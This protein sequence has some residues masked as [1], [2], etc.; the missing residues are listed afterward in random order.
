MPTLPI[1]VQKLVDL[2]KNEN[3][4]FS[5]FARVIESDSGFASRILKV[6]N[7]AYYGL[8]IKATTL[9]RAI[10]ALGL[11]YVKS[12]TLGYHL[13]NVL[14]SFQTVG[15]NMDNYWRESLLRAVMA[16]QI[17]HRYCPDH[18]EEAF[19][20]G[21]LQN[22]GI[23]FLVQAFG[24]PYAE[25]WS[26]IQKSP[27]TL[28]QLERKLFQFNHLKAAS[29]ITKQWA[30]PE[31]LSEPI[32]MHHY[33]SQSE[34]SIADEVK[35]CQ[36]AYFVGTLSLANIDS[37]SEDD[38]TLAD[39][40]QSAFGLDKPAL[41]EILE[42]TRQEFYSVAQLFA[43]IVPDKVDVAELL[44]NANEML[45]ELAHDSYLKTFD[46]EAELKQL[47]DKCKKLSESAEFYRHQDGTDPLTGL[48]KQSELKAYLK[49]SS[50][51][52][53]KGESEMAVLF[54]DIDDFS[55]FKD[56][57]G[58]VLA[59][60]LLQ[61]IGQLLQNIFSDNGC[62]ARYGGDEIV[63]VLMGLLQKQAVV[64]AEALVHKISQI[65]IKTEKTTLTATCSIGMV[66]CESKADIK[67][68]EQ[69]LDLADRQ[70]Y[71]VK[72]NGKNNFSYQVIP[73][74]KKPS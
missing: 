16:R 7:S 5:E 74:Q 25:L 64:L 29:L 42:K 11:K 68:T 30:L 41:R 40:C 46:L 21:L 8:R 12:I 72:N 65:T 60:S 59:D 63:I 50:E 55:S 66:F 3:A 37:I 10:S 56:Q 22:C 26:N 51:K 34:P 70:M 43:G 1:V 35:L 53:R 20:I 67:D 19:L 4:N 36:V 47:E 62:V 45:C 32:C 38:I 69:I 71:L 23:P 27:G 48:A 18:S 44:S 2:C 6:A 58:H 17:A 31:L 13:A 39:F 14:N 54:I 61:E 24:K 57:F 49:E 52:V 28:Y 33:R 73:T 15:F 9:D